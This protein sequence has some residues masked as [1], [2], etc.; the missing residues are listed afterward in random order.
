M[1]LGEV[2]GQCW[3]G[4]SRRSNYSFSHTLLKHVLETQARHAKE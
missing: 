2:V 4:L 3:Y 1:S